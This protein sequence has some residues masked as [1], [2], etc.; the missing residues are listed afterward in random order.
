MSDEPLLLH[1]FSS[2]SGDTGSSP[3]PVDKAIR[4]ECPDMMAS[5]RGE[6]LPSMEHRSWHSFDVA[7]RMFIALILSI[8]YI[9]LLSVYAVL[10]PSKLVKWLTCSH[11][12]L[13]MGQMTGQH[14]RQVTLSV[15]LNPAH[16]KLSQSLLP[17]SAHLTLFLQHKSSG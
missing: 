9:I 2:S 12:A 3:V 7:I 8:R 5:Q 10:L 6:N 4:A 16:S 13:D 14:L 1:V 11:M 15:S 17:H